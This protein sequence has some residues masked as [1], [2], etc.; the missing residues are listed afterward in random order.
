MRRRPSLG[1]AFVRNRRPPLRPF[2]SL[3]LIVRA[4]GLAIADPRSHDVVDVTIDDVEAIMVLGTASYGSEGLARPDR[5]LFD[6]LTA[7]DLLID[8]DDPAQAP[9]IE[10]SAPIAVTERTIKPTSVRVIT[11][12][13]IRLHEG[14]PLAW[15]RERGV[16]R[17]LSA[18]HLRVVSDMVHLTGNGTAA[19]RGVDLAELR[20][21]GIIESFEPETDPSQSS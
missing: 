20:S 18:A 4:V 3:L 10:A 8:R 9:V 2:P 6:R 7:L 1:A 14:R 16:Y 13:V 17:E 21:V 19:P 5:S 12:S 11:P 15:D